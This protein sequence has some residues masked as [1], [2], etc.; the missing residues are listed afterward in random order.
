MTKRTERMLEFN[1]LPTTDTLVLA[2]LLIMPWMPTELLEIILM[3]LPNCPEPACSIPILLSPTY[4]RS[5]FANACILVVKSCLQFAPRGDIFKYLQPLFP[6]AEEKQQRITVQ[7][8]AIRLLFT[9]LEDP[10]IR[11]LIGTLHTRPALHQDVR[12]VLLKSMLAIIGSGQ[13]ESHPFE[14]LAWDVLSSAAAN[15]AL[16]INGVCGTLLC[17]QKSSQGTATGNVQN[18]NVSMAATISLRWAVLHASAFSHL[19]TIHYSVCAPLSALITQDY[20]G[21]LIDSVNSPDSIDILSRLQARYLSDVLRPLTSRVDLTEMTKHEAAALLESRKAA[22]LAI[23]TQWVSPQD[24][25]ELAAEWYSFWVDSFKLSEASG[26]RKAEVDIRL[27]LA[28]GVGVCAHHDRSGQA[29]ELLLSILRKWASVVADLTVPDERRFEAEKAIRDLQLGSEFL[30]RDSPS[31]EW[32]AMSLVQ[33]LMDYDICGIFWEAIVERHIKS[34]ILQEPASACELIGEA[35]TFFRDY[36]KPHILDKGNYSR[37][38]YFI[39]QQEV[40]STLFDSTNGSLSD[41]RFS[42]TLKIAFFDMSPTAFRNEIIEWFLDITKPHSNHH[43]YYLNNATQCHALLAKSLPLDPLIIFPEDNI[44]SSWNDDDVNIVVSC[45]ARAKEAG[46]EGIHGSTLLEVLKLAPFACIKFQADNLWNFI[47]HRITTDPYA[48]TSTIG[49]VLRHIGLYLQTDGMKNP[50]VATAN[51][52][53]A[54]FATHLMDGDLLRWA[55]QRSVHNDNVPQSYSDGACFALTVENQ[56]HVQ[57]GLSEEKP[58]I[59]EHERSISTVQDAQRLWDA[60]VKPTVSETPSRADSDST[61]S[62]YRQMAIDFLNAGINAQ[63]VVYNPRA[64]I[65]FMRS[66]LSETHQILSHIDFAKVIVDGLRPRGS[67]PGFKKWAPS[68]MMGLD[69]VELILQCATEEDTPSIVRSSLEMVAAHVLDGWTGLILEPHAAVPYLIQLA[70]REALETRFL[71][72]R[73]SVWK[74][75]GRAIGLKVRNPFV[76]KSDDGIDGKRVVVSIA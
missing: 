68:L 53:V 9:Y 63:A 52:A 42:M 47:K 36:V 21:S 28:K 34:T 31:P 66:C 76:S 4:L 62:A 71:T 50:N 72:V 51:F 46:W 2:G 43:A 61:K 8:E 24:A 37:R 73:A 23:S 74:G 12:V 13:W 38:R 19:H 69:F 44:Y 67:L 33:P 56:T 40:F 30:T 27:A 35:A 57:G 18:E 29:W 60:W 45:V 32:D 15:P 26:V 1:K 70:G 22:Y 59:G 55:L 6:P 39:K 3:H 5:E 25:A 75:H 16:R 49:P 41:T 10:D 64:Y 17:V 54:Q 7:K 58:T 11:D 65:L 14:Q 20:A 48:A